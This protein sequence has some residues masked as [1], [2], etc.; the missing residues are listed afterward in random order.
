MQPSLA[1]TLDMGSKR[2]NSEEISSTGKSRAVHFFV[3]QNLVRPRRVPVSAVSVRYTLQ[4][5]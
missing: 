3:A 2:E 5:A 4:E 1:E